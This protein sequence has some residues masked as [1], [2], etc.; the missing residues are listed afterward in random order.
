MS[1]QSSTRL[2]ASSGSSSQEMGGEKF[3]PSQVQLAGMKSVY[4]T[5]ELVISMMFFLH[6]EIVSVFILNARY[7]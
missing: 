4:L 6:F 5:A 2:F 3:S 7:K 1:S